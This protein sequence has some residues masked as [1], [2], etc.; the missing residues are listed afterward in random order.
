VARL[1]AQESLAAYYVKSDIEWSFRGVADAM[2]RTHKDEYLLALWSLLTVGLFIPGVREILKPGWDAL[3]DIH[4][5]A[6]KVFLYGWTVIFAATFSIRGAMNLLYP[7]RA[8]TL[9]QAMGQAPE[10]VPM[11]AAR[12]AQASVDATTGMVRMPAEE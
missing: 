11:D 12:D 10:D 2:S 6:P 8:A 9:V 1:K 5:D 3:R 4:E 7:N